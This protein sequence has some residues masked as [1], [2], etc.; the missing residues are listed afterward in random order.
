MRF[1][2]STGPGVRYQRFPASVHMFLRGT[3]HDTNVP[4]VGGMAQSFYAWRI[5][6]MTKSI[7]LVGLIELVRTTILLVIFFD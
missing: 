3:F 7:W 5:Y 4:T 6:R 2:C 1:L